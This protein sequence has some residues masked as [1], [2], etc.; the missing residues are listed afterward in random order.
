M[1]VRIF[2][3]GMLIF[4]VLALPVYA[5]TVTMNLKI[6]GTNPVYADSSQ[7]TT[8]TNFVNMN[9]KYLITTDNTVFGVV[10]AGSR[11]I[12]ASVKTSPTSFRMSQNYDDNRFLVAFTK[13]SW[14]R[15]DE[16]YESVGKLLSTTFG[17][18]SKQVVN[19]F[20]VYLNLQYYD[21]DIIN[22][23]SWTGQKS[24]LIKNEGKDGRGL[25]KVSIQPIS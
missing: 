2:L 1:L 7:I 6:D 23:L 24:L 21:I 19:A 20:P 22:N 4:L 8:D 17:S 15:F 18:F 12:D 14:Q 3:V 25:T 9:K 13:T 11:F 10:F 16:K 5:H